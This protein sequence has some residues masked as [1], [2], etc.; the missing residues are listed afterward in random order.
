MTARLLAWALGFPA[1]LTI[2]KA[3]VV[4]VK[5]ETTFLG[6]FTKITFNNGPCVTSCGGPGT[7]Y[8]PQDCTERG[9]VAAGPCAQGFG[10]CCSFIVTTCGA[11]VVQNCTKLRGSVALSNSCVFN[12]G[13]CSADVCFNRLSFNDLV[14]PGIDSGGGQCT[15]K[16]ISF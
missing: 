2:S 6:F 14:L 1:L 16:T 9:G 13:R 8:K 5:A 7:C 15:S 3:D 10:V 12:L 4:V 11:D